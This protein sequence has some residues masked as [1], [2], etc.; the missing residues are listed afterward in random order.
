MNKIAFYEE[1]TFGDKFN[2]TFEFIRQNWKIMLRYVSYVVLPLCLL[3]GLLLHVLIDSG[4]ISTKDEWTQSSPF[5]GSYVGIV[6]V[7]SLAS[8]WVATVVFSLMQV[9]NYRTDGLQGV[10]TEDL[11][12]YFK[13][14]AWRLFKLNLTALLLCLLY[15]ISA[16]ILGALIPVLAV[17]LVLISLLL[18]FVPL[19]LV[20]PVYIYEDISVW[21]A[22]GRGIRLGWNTWG[23]IFAL[24]IV[25]TLLA[26]V[27]EGIMGIP[28]QI[29]YLLKVTLADY[30]NGSFVNSVGFSLLSYVT[31][32]VMIYA[33]LLC[34]CLFFVSI[35]YLYSHA[36]EQ[37]D[38]MSVEEGI[39]NFEEMADPN[40]D[41]ETVDFDK[42]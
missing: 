20:G 21:K 36:A 13:H 34:S 28:W 32:C 33:Q 31:S 15:G 38:D 17:L 2:V 14:N 9:Y 4:L 7:M 8:W 10:T 5:F 11:K 25:M 18:L 29:C 3:S 37:E 16:S 42:L 1:R 6:A 40:E 19:L 27:A 41:A 39:K 12:P 23:G 22:W 26:S 35:S 24:G 30:D